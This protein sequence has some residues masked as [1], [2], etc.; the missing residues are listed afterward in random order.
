MSNSIYTYGQSP[1]GGVITAN[2]NLEKINGVTVAV[3]SG[4]VNSG[5]QRVTIAT[6]DAG[7]AAIVAYLAHIDTVLDTMEISMD[8]V[9]NWNQNNRCKGSPIVGQDGVAA[10]TGVVGATTQRVTIATNDSIVTS[11]ALLDDA[12][13]T[14]SAVT[15]SKG[16]VV[17]FHDGANFQRWVGEA[18]DSSMDGDAVQPNVNAYMVYSYTAGEAKAWHGDNVSDTLDPSA[19]MPLVGSYNLFWDPTSNKEM[20]WRAE[21]WD[22]NISTAATGASPTV[23][24]LGTFWNADAGAGYG[25]RWEGETW[26]S[27]L[28]VVVNPNV[29]SFGVFKDNTTGK[30]T[31][32]VGERWDDDMGIVNAPSVNAL[33]VFL[34][35]TGSKN[36]QWAGELWSADMTGP[37]AA[38]NVNAFSAFRD[39]TNNKSVWL[40]GI[41]AGDTMPAT[42][43]APFTLSLGTFYNG[44]NYQRWTGLAT[45]VDGRTNDTP[46]PWVANLN[47]G[48]NGA[49]WDRIRTG[50][51]AM[52]EIGRAHV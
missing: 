37:T 46:A 41:P 7:L 49:T 36:R 6:N 42:Q 14:Q 8:T 22:T 33:N 35:A 44:T 29:N 50:S 26:D 19:N 20:R 13:G 4:N 16:V 45:A 3:G 48:Y 17:G 28:S 23:M 47:Y 15:P 21:P 38:P 51:G 27:D 25:S 11:L 1:G 31:Q 10:N 40:N 12:I 39:T 30:N 9:D 43:V 32:W 5:T 2:S 24:S 18:Y 52:G 34:D